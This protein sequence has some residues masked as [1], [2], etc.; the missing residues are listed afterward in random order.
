MTVD[1]LKKLLR[2]LPNELE[3]IMSSDPEGNSF[4][5]LN[6]VEECSVTNDRELRPLHP[7]DIAEFKEDGGKV[8][9]MVC[10]WP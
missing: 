6:V 4:D 7:D 1:E 5:T 10:L 2:K 9:R 3:V 8:V